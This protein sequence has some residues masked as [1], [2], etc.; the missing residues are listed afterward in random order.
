ML[1]ILFAI[2][3][4]CE[5][6]Q[7]FW[8]DSFNSEEACYDKIDC[9]TY[10]EPIKVPA[11]VQSKFESALNDLIRNSNCDL[12]FFYECEESDWEDYLECVAESSCEILVNP[13]YLSKLP[14]EEWIAVR[15]NGLKNYE[16]PEEDLENY[17]I[18]Q[19]CIIDCE[20]VCE[21]SN[22]DDRE[23]LENCVLSFCV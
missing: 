20:E 17:Y 18:F 9:D 14:E 8:C 22:D 21:A 12:E 1:F 6:S 16:V 15:A 4:A 13:E 5:L 11:S 19:D 2:A 3:N 10:G 23:C 7:K